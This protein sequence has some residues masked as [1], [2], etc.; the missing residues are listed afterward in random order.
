MDDTGGSSQIRYE[1]AG[2]LAGVDFHFA[3]RLGS[4]AGSAHT[5][6]ACTLT[7]HAPA[8]PNSA[9]K[10]RWRRVAA[11][12]ASSTAAGCRRY[13]RRAGVRSASAACQ[14]HPPRS[15]ALRDSASARD[16][17]RRQPRLIAQLA[18]TAA[19]VEHRDDGVQMEPGCA[20]PPS[21][22]GRPCRH[23][24]SRCSAGAFSSVAP[25]VAR[26]WLLVAGARCRCR[27]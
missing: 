1:L 14:Q 24:S 4:V 12:A 15:R 2:G 19:A 18:G 11:S 27:C 6:A 22:L 23:R 20:S 3:A 26:C 16:V 25:T 10:C 21:R 9:R 5:D 7:G 17:A 13:G 8:A